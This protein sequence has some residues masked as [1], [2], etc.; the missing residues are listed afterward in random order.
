VKKKMK[1]KKTRTILVSL[2]IVSTLLFGTLIVAAAPEG[3][4]DP[5]QEL[6]NAIFGIR[7]DVADLQDDVDY[8][9]RIAELQS[10]VDTLQAKVDLIDDP[11]IQGPP[12]ETGP[13]GPEGPR[14]DP[15]PIGPSGPPGET[16]PQGPAGGFETP[17]YDSGWRPISPGYS[18]T[19]SDYSLEAD[20]CFVYVYGRFES[21]MHPG[22]WE[23]HQNFL[24]GE[25]YLATT[26]N[27]EGLQW[28]SEDISEYVTLFRRGNDTYWHE[29][30]VLIWTINT[31]S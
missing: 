13:Q 18:I 23:Y 27:V 19:I 7:E 31:P 1:I 17:D 25:R 29:V 20:D 24:G 22:S 21:Q 16:G 8:L 2:I 30:R 15:G 6:W 5:F 9:G 14:G 11:W 12:G 3:V 26:N 4:T 10:Q 28:F